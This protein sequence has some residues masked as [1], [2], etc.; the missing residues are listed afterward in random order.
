MPRRA[1]TRPL[2]PLATDFRRCRSRLGPRRRRAASLVGNQ[3]LIDRLFRDLDTEKSGYALLADED[4]SFDYPHH[5]A[6][7]HTQSASGSPR[8]RLSVVLCGDRRGGSPFHRISLFGYD[9][10]GRQALEQIGLSV[11][12]ARKGS[13]GWRFETGSADMGVIAGTVERISGRARRAGSLQRT[14]RAQSAIWP[15]AN[16]LPFMPAVVGAGGHGHGRRARRFRRGHRRRVGEARRAGVRPRHR[17]HAQL[18]RQRDRHPQLD[19]QVPR[20]GLSQLVE[21][22]GAVPRG[23]H[24]RARPELPVDAAHPRRGQRGDREQRVAPAEEPLDRQGRGRADRPLSKATTST[25]KRRSSC[26]RSIASST[27]PTIATATSRS[28]TAPTRRAACWK[29]HSFVRACRT[30][31]SAA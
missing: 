13:S 18:R 29:S 9:D 14:R 25:T 3:A 28:S 15:T 11:R 23:G 10:E 27:A 7:G 21:V 4:L 31:C 16:S 5:A 2:W 1:C 6:H 26:A 8:R 12:P 19:L 22:R 17:P 20:G 24:G 30:A